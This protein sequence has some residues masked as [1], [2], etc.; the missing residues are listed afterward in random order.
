M[1]GYAF[2]YVCVCVCVRARVRMHTQKGARTV[3]GVDLCI[4]YS[5]SHIIVES[6]A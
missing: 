2:S 1:F 3:N 6:D 5:K 4:I